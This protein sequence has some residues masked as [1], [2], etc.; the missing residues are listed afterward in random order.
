MG[1]RTDLGQPK[2]PRFADQ[3][4]EN[5]ATA[6][7]IPDLSVRLVVY[8]ESDEALEPVSTRIEYTERRVAGPG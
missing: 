7:Q 2:R 1:M 4:A 6:R 8:S 3:N 5:A